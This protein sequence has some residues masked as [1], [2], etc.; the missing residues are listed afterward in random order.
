MNDWSLH[1][2]RSRFLPSQTVTAELSASLG[3]ESSQGW[4]LHFSFSWLGFPFPSSSAWAVYCSPGVLGG[5]LVRVQHPSSHS[6]GNNKGEKTKPTTTKPKSKAWLGEYLLSCWNQNVTPQGGMGKLDSPGRFL[7]SSQGGEM[8]NSPS[9]SPTYVE[10]IQ[11]GTAP[12][13]GTAKQ[14]KLNFLNIFFKSTVPQIWFWFGFSCQPDP[15]RVQFSFKGEKPSGSASIIFDS[16]Q[17]FQFYV[18]R[19]SQRSRAG[20]F[21]P[22]LCQAHNPSCLRCFCR[23][24]PQSC[25]N[26]FDTGLDQA[27][28][29]FKHGLKCIWVKTPT[30]ERHWS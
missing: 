18:D 7:P 4:V 3:T 17:H 14:L 10:L 30:K 5:F 1:C 11:G 15:L 8:P 23:E 19:K 29:R 20:Y 22:R 26:L 27:E 16:L 13:M 12:D 25:L 2:S 28:V 6:S 9:E 24:Q 21:P